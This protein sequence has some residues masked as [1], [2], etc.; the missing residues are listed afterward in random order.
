MIMAKPMIILLLR[1]PNYF[2]KILC[3]IRTF[4]I[5]SAPPP[6]QKTSP[7]Q[8]LGTPSFES[9]KRLIKPP[10]TFLRLRVPN[11]QILQIGDLQ[12]TSSNSITPFHNVDPKLVH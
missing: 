6:I 10:L 1:T 12:G 11:L 9:Q 4:V 5:L 3:P 2:A 7:N 8:N